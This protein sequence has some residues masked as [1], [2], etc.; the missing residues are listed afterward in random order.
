MKK[1]IL[2]IAIIGLS[3]TYSCEKEDL[4]SNNNNTTTY[5]LRFTNTSSNPYDVYVNGTTKT[6]SGNSYIN[7]NLE[8]DSYY[9]TVTQLSGYALYPTIQEGTVYLTEDKNVVFP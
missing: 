4:P 1:L 7:Y 6:L 2:L 3:L 5:E 8:M 9:W